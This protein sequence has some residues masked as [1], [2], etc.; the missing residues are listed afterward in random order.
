MASFLELLPILVNIGGG[1][2]E[3]LGKGKAGKQLI[4]A[5][6]PSTPFY[7]TYRSLPSWQVLW[8]NALFG[9]LRDRLGEETL[10]RW[11][12]NPE[13][14]SSQI[15]RPVTSSKLLRDAL[16]SKYLK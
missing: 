8:Q 10:R 13:G 12:I 6:R 14:F 4:E 11:G 7:E 2:A 16:L 1:I 9:A 15:Q 3:A 5:T